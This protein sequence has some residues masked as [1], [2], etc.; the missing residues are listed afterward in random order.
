M[1]LSDVNYSGAQFSWTKP[2]WQDYK[3]EHPAA[4]RYVKRLQE[5]GLKDPW[6]RNYVWIYSP[7]IHKTPWQ[8]CKSCFFNRLPHGLAIAIAYTFAQT[9]FLKW[10]HEKGYGEAHAHF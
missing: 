10:Y 8:I 3:V 5:L 4:V 6:V 1:H 2:N 9:A 7:R